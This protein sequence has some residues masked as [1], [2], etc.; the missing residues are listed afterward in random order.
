ME[1]KYSAQILKEMVELSKERTSYK[2]HMG[3]KELLSNSA[4]DS[5]VLAGLNSYT[6]VG[7]EYKF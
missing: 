7:L 5:R 2:T 6:N 4:C 1:E 3:H